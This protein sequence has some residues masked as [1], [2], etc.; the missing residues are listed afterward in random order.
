M[1]HLTETCD[2]GTPHLV[3][4]ADTTPANVHEAMRTEP[5]HAALAAKGLAPVEH[6]VDAAYVSA[7]HLVTAHECHGIDLIGLPRPVQNCQ[8]QEKDAFLITDFIVDWDRHCARCSEGRGCREWS[9]YRDRTTGRPYIRANLSPADC[10]PCLARARCTHAPSRRLTLHTRDR[11]EALATT[12]ARLSSE[13]GQRPYAQR[14]GVECTIS[15]AVRAFGLRR[16][17]YR[18]L[19]KTGLQSLATAAA[20]NLDRLAA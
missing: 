8:T 5:I 11:H 18:G 17:P 20:I 4:Y 3:L 13:A 12:R 9:E 7:K 14:Q 16:A 2:A 15:Q 6:L 1:V 19:A 10:Q